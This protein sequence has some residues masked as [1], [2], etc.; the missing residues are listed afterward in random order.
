M[1]YGLWSHLCL[2]GLPVMVVVVGVCGDKILV[3][4]RVRWVGEGWGCRRNGD[5]W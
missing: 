1:D 2:Y 4:V 3:D 5:R